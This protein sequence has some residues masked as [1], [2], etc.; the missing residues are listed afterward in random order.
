VRREV[1]T[2]L[3]ADLAEQVL[4]G[5]G[6][7]RLEVRG[8]SMRPTLRT[9]DR[10]TLAPREPRLLRAG[11]LVAV[12]T[13]EGMRVHRFVGLDEKGWVR[14]AGD[15]VDH[16]DAP[17][18]EQSL[19]GEVIEVERDGCRQR[20]VVGRAALWR[21]EARRVPSALRRRLGRSLRRLAGRT[22]S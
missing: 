9:G 2:L 6:S 19:L 12:R 15:A 1:P 7:V 21:W 8:D 17:V 4:R 16:R 22:D 3:L 14:T 18:P 11:C 5:E 10:V 20:P 13:P